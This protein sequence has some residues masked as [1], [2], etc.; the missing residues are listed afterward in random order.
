M[1]ASLSPSVT[2]MTAP[3]ET[4]ASATSAA[5]A[6]PH[7]DHAGKGGRF[8]DVLSRKLKS[9]ENVP[10]DEAASALASNP[11]AHA[12]V[13]HAAPNAVMH[14]LTL[15]ANAS[16]LVQQACPLDQHATND[17]S[18]DDVSDG[19]SHT[20][21][22]LPPNRA[23]T[24]QDAQR[25]IPA[26][27]RMVHVSADAARSAGRVTPA[28]DVG[29]NDDPVHGMRK[30]IHTANRLT[31]ARGTQT[32]ARSAATPSASAQ[33]QHRPSTHAATITDVTQTGAPSSTGAQDPAPGSLA[34]LAAS[35]AGDMGNPPI[36]TQAFF[37]PS[38]SAPGMPSTTAANA[39]IGAIAVPM[40]HPQWSQMLG[41]HVLHLSQ[42]GVQGPQTAE[43]RLDPPELGP[44]RI[45]IELRDHVAHATFVSAHAPVRLAVETALPQL[46][47]HLAQAGIALGQT[48]VSGEGASGQDDSAR[49]TPTRAIGHRASLVAHTAHRAT[50]AR[51]PHALI[52]TFA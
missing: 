33:A 7:P 10:D 23:G 22:A 35:Q 26:T 44:L 16:A 14:A 25:I 36:L 37:T 42:A 32:V 9:D 5:A 31:T 1:T 41:Q 46:Q 3:A 48:S 27:P 4:V 20:V 39:S 18:V 30:H 28:D 21:A 17:A 49:Q 6:A 15:S 13:N 29:G 12:T 34:N 45:T 24:Q 47:G 11:E 38:A 19:G 40:H 52:D 8:A 50:V 43:L 51:N 2:T